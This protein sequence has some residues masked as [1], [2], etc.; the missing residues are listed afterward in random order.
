MIQNISFMVI[1][2]PSGQGGNIMITAD[3]KVVDLHVYDIKRARCA[4]KKWL[5]ELDDVK[6]WYRNAAS[7]PTI[8]IPAS[9]GFYS[10]TMKLSNGPKLAW[11]EILGVEGTCLLKGYVDAEELKTALKNSSEEKNVSEGEEMRIDVG[12]MGYIIQRGELSALFTAKGKQLCEFK[13]AEF[14]WYYSNVQDMLFVTDI[15]SGDMYYIDP[16]KKE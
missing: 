1:P 15:L 9:P 12:R 5:K 10:V 4:F 7:N 11:I 14:D 13:K 3:D 2:E 16:W 6:G 8:Y